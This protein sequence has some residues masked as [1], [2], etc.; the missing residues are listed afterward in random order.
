MKKQNSFRL[1]FLAILIVF[2]RIAFALPPT[3]T[4]DDNSWWVYASSML[5]LSTDTIEIYTPSDLAAIASEFTSTG[6]SLAGKTVM[7]MNDI[8]LGEHWWMPIGWSNSAF[9]GVFDGNNKRISNLYINSPSLDY[10]GLFGHTVGSA[11]QIKNVI[12]ESGSITANAYSGAIVGL[13]DSTLVTNCHNAI[14]ITATSS[15]IGGIVGR[16]DNAI[17]TNCSNSAD[18][19]TIAGY[20]GGIVGEGINGR[21][22]ISNCSNSGNISGNRYVGGVIGESV[23]MK[24]YM[25]YCT[26]SGKITCSGAYGGGIAGYVSSTYTVIKYCRNNGDVSTVSSYAGGIAGH[27]RLILG[28]INDGSIYGIDASGG[29]AGVAGGV[30][31]CINNGKVRAKNKHVG[32]LVGRVTTYARN[33]INHAKASSNDTVAGVVGYVNNPTTTLDSCIN[34][35]SIYGSGAMQGAVAGLNR[36]LVRNCFYDNQRCSQ[37][38]ITK[39]DTIGFAEGIATNSLLGESLKSKLD[40]AIWKFTPGYYPELKV[41][42]DSLDIEA[43]AMSAL[44]ATPIYLDPTDAVWRITKNFT[45]PLTDAAGNA[46]TWTLSAGNGLSIN[47]STGEVLVSLVDTLTDIVLTAK[48]SVNKTKSASVFRTAQTISSSKEFNLVNANLAT[49][50]M[51]SVGEEHNFQIYPNPAIDF[52]SVQGLEAESTYS[53]YDVAGLLIDQGQLNANSAKVNVAALKSGTYLLKVNN[54]AL[55]FIKK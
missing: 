33:N 15:Y 3:G 28:C 29:I 41:I 54:Q 21:T 32:G 46:I 51:Q 20:I 11:S 34:T 37:G 26:N 39:V 43:R 4:P 18:M 7:L 10:Q 24:G 35:S 8:D 5:D 52:I 22:I 9:D 38:G 2:S 14:P 25:A 44:A 1:F 12:L 6:H 55:P 17:V 50:S 53:I 30:Q 16:A 42:L 13:A 45:L 48:T 47:E 27:G 49:S 36:G 19:T 23:Y 40:T 31:K